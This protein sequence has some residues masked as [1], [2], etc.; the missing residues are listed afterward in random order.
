MV[1]SE[2][3]SARK[4]GKGTKPKLFYV[5]VDGDLLQPTMMQHQET[6]LWAEK[7]PGEDLLALSSEGTS[8]PASGMAREVYDV[9]HPSPWG[10]QIAAYLWTKSIGAGVLLVSALLLAMGYAGEK[11]LTHVMSPVLALIFTG[12]TSYLLVTDLKRPDRFH[13]VLTKPN[14]K[15]WLVLGS[16]ILIFYTLFGAI[17]LLLGLIGASIP[18]TL[19]WLT[20]ILA[21]GSACYSAFLFAQAKGR[22]LWESPLFLWHLLLQAI[23]AGAATLIVFGVI[24]QVGS[25]AMQL[26]GKI[27]IL[28]LLFSLLM[29]LGEISLTPVSEDA[30]R[31]VDLL[32]RG[33]L[34]GRFWGLVIILGIALPLIFLSWSGLQGSV[35]YGSYFL[36]SIF[37]LAGLWAFENLWVEAGQAV[38]LS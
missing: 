16:Y 22:D 32:T 34:G 18:S 1:V 26:L 5:G 12:L 25:S 20:A 28:S 30:R 8:E 9:S 15:S 21:V 38:P 7:Q 33:T 10:K 29:I 6:Y 36:A 23:T 11:A 31:P 13:Y 14:L 3:V 37:S 35:S 2:K 24:L 17:W 19:F 4:P 27:L